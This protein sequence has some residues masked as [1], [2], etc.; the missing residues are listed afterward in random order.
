MTINK[1][2]YT[3]SDASIYY[4]QRKGERIVLGLSEDCGSDGARGLLW[5]YK[6][7]KKMEKVKMQ[8][9]LEVNDAVHPTQ[10]KKKNR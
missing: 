8:G 10:L 1:E 4:V 5:Y 2:L 7:A 6:A 3:K 9:T